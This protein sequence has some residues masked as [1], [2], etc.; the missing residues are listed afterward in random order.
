ML[1]LKPVFDKRLG[2]TSGKNIAGKIRGFA[3]GPEGV[4]VVNYSGPF[5]HATIRKFDHDGDYLFNLTPPP[6]ELPESK[7]AGL[8]YIDYEPGK[9]AVHGP[10]LNGS[11]QGGFCPPGLGPRA[12][13]IQSVLVGNRLVFTTRG[14]CVTIR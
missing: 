13:T 14:K 10:S 12:N 3:I 4:C 9:R 2:C 7:R 8:S 11:I 1:G 5:S 6:R